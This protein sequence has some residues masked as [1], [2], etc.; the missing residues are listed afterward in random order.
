W[1]S[2]WRRCPGWQSGPG[3]ADPKLVR[4]PRSPSPPQCSRHFLRLSRGTRPRPVPGPM[5]LAALPALVLLA[6]PADPPVE[7]VP[8][9]LR[10]AY[11]QG[12]LQEAYPAV[13]DLRHL[14]SAEAAVDPVVALLRWLG[15]GGVAAQLLRLL[16]IGAAIVAVLLGALWIAGKLA[17]R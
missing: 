10:Q 9:A 12:N 3:G 17:E 5:L 1:G 16:G 4:A 7:R 11:A 14:Q 2:S 13:V 8:E 15:L 6:A